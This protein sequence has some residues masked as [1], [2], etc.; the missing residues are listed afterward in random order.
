M[1][2][3]KIVRSGVDNPLGSYMR[4][5]LY[6]DTGTGKTLL[7][8]SAVRSL[9]M[10]K[11]LYVNFDDGLASM[12]H[13]PGISY[14]KPNS[15]AEVMWLKAQLAKPPASRDKAL[16]DIETIVVDSLSAGRDQILAELVAKGMTQAKNARTEAILQVQDYGHMQF[17]LTDFM[18]SL[19]QQPFHIITT[20]GVKYEYTADQLTGASPL[21]N[22]G[23]L[24]SI[25]HMM[26]FIWYT[27]KIGGKYKL[28]T[29]DKG[30]YQ[31]KT[32]NP[33]FERA[34]RAETEKLAKAAG[35]AN[36]AGQ[37]GWYTLALDENDLP[38]PGLDNLYEL[39]VSSTKE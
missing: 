6:G 30:I 4:V 12:E 13:V 23:L 36:P 29:L 20:A 28:L 9:K 2:A 17:A 35:N 34:I 15:L 10:G 8:G 32:R 31:A 19:R 14:V 27:A 39:F 26:S 3:P 7:T 37:Q 16:Q 5:L 21:L 11:V 25:S 24:Q 1:A 22:P 33:R 38:T 18:S